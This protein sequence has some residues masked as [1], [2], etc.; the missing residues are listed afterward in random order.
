MAMA[1]AGAKTVWMQLGVID[2]EAAKKAADAGLSIVM[3]LCMLR[4]HKRLL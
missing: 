1:K 2:K 3:D 4:E